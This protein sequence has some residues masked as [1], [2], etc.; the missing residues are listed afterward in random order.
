MLYKAVCWQADCLLQCPKRTLGNL[1]AGFLEGSFLTLPVSRS[2]VCPLNVS[3]CIFHGMLNGEI[4]LFSFN[5]LHAYRI[6]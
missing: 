3:A 1:N 6:K 2:H 5:L 4:S